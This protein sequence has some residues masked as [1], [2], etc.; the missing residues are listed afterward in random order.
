LLSLLGHFFV[1]ARAGIWLK[2]TGVNDDVLVSA[3]TALT[4][5]TIAREACIVC[6][7]GVTT[8]GET[9]KERGLAYIGASYQSQYG[10][11]INLSVGI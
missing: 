11:Q 4:I 3:L 8:F 2:T 6:D 9:V 10:F 5:V 1:D 7:D